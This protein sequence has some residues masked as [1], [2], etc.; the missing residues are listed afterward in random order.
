[1]SKSVMKNYYSYVETTFLADQTVIL[2]IKL[3]PFVSVDKFSGHLCIP[4]L[5]R[6]KDFMMAVFLSKNL[7]NRNFEIKI[8][9][10]FVFSGA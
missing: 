10:L 2:I 7:E 6:A 5:F 8:M 1:M 4:L 9:I 3:T